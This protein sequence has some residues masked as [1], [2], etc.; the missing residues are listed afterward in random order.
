ME[1]VLTV[2]W[3]LIDNLALL[4]FLS[5]FLPV[6]RNRTQIL[7]CYLFF[8]VGQIIL[9]LVIPGPLHPIVS[10]I[11]LLLVSFYLFDGKLSTRLILC[12]NALLIMTIMDAVAGYGIS[13]ILGLSIE[14][15]VSRK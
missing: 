9:M 12:V 6:K 15:F 3:T 11:V 5:A 8:T 13:A 4:L 1:Y 14:E 10:S 7:L 2:L